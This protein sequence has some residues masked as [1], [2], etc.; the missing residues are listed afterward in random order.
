MNGVS[1][2]KLLMLIKDALPEYQ[3]SYFST[4]TIALTNGCIVASVTPGTADGPTISL[5]ERCKQLLGAEIL[6]EQQFTSL[7]YNYGDG[8]ESVIVNGHQVYSGVHHPYGA[9]EGPNVCEWCGS[10]LNI[11]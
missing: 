9:C 11:D 7:L 3:I 2:T 6:P 5:A 8:Y 4:A 10:V 1:A